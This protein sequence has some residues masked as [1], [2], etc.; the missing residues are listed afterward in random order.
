MVDP[1]MREALM[2]EARAQRAESRGGILDRRKGGF[3]AFKALCLASVAFKWCLML[4]FY[5]AELWI[6]AERRLISIGRYRICF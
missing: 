3:R 1:Y 4:E 6:P 5:Q 2:A